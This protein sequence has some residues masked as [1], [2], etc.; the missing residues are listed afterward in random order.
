MGVFVFFGQ[1]FYL[2]KFKIQAN[3]FFLSFFLL[4]FSFLGHELQQ[5]LKNYNLDWSG[6]GSDE[7]KH[8]ILKQTG[9]G[10]FLLDRRT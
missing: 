7:M 5:I 2:F 1:L 8:E 9:F 10:H 6:V 3:V 4:F